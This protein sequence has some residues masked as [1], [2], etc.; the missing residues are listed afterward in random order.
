ML[1]QATK[2][3]RWKVGIEGIEGIG[4]YGYGYGYGYRR[5][6]EG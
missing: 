3:C 1:S 4:V 6:Y 2:E 5:G